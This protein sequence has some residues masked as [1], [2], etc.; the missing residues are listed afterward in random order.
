M[1][2]RPSVNLLP[3]I[4]WKAPNML[5]EAVAMG[6]VRMFLCMGGFAVV[7][8][9]NMKMVS[10][11]RIGMSAGQW[12]VME[13]LGIKG[14]TEM[15]KLKGECKALNNKDLSLGQKRVSLLQKSY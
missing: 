11:K 6:T 3:V 9:C 4:T 12:N 7:S 15:E 13:H 10:Q 1:L 8:W 2:T 5:T 14:Y